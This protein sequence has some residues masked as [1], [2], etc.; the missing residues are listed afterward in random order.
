MVNTDWHSLAFRYGKTQLVAG[1]DSS[2]QSV[3][4]V[5]RNADTGEL[6]RQGRASHPEGTE[7]DPQ[8]WKNARARTC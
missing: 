3:K 2:T 4:V 5:I 8:L 1:V 7:V 6:V